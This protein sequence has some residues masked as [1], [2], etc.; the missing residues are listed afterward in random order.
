LL[1]L[2]VDSVIQAL[3]ENPDLSYYVIFNNNKN[4]GSPVSGWRHN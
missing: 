4:N 2:A 3:I 1:N